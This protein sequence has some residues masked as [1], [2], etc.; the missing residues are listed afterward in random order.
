M[1]NNSL[2]NNAQNFAITGNFGITGPSSQ[3]TLVN[4]GTFSKT[5][6]GSFSDIGPFFTQ[7]G[8]GDINVSAGVLRFNGDAEI[9]G[10]NVAV[11]TRLIFGGPTTFGSPVLLPP[12][13]N[14]NR[15][16]PDKKGAS[17]TSRQHTFTSSTNLI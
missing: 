8:T 1:A 17:A 9:A 11:S 4:A 13:L 12:S 10:G 2:F 16:V 14:L 15:N 6:G 5:G 7:D 3:N